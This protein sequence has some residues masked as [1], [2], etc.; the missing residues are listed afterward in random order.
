MITVAS[1]NVLHRVHAENYAEE[2]AARWPH[3]SRRIAAVTAKL[4]AR[5]ED[6]IALQEVSGDQL[7]SLRAALP[8]GTVHALRYPRVPAIRRG[9]PGLRDVTEHL[10]VLARGRTVAGQAFDGD[11]GKGYLAVR[12]DAALVVSTHVGFGAASTAQLA[13]LAE[14]ARGTGG[15]ALLLGD[16]NAGRATVAAALGPEFVI[17]AL[18]GD[19]RPTRPG[20]RTPHIDHVIAFGIEVSTAAVEDAG[21]LSD[22]N[23]VTAAAGPRVALRPAVPPDVEAVAELR[24]VVLR[25]DLERLGRYDEQR[26]RRRLRDAFTPAHTWIIEVEGAFAGCVSLRP[27]GDAVWLEH[28]YLAP[29]VQGRG[30][31]TSVLRDLLRRCDRDGTRVRLNVLRGSPARR[32]YERHGFTLETEDPIDVYLV[33]EPG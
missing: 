16:F 28:F 24:A 6:V 11:P 30:I 31:G 1:W 27:S 12:T 4:A 25:T 18:P 15:P 17:A 7:A 32:L 3:E 20:A 8:D 14:V 10:V 9:E 2:V 23:L 22:H 13:R 33:R 26:V 21:G 29:H 5:A 19:A